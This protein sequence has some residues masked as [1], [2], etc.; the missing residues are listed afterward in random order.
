MVV[1]TRFL[2]SLSSH[3]EELPAFGYKNVGM[4]NLVLSTSAERKGSMPHNLSLYAAV[5]LHAKAMESPCSRRNEL[6]L[7]FKIITEIYRG[8]RGRR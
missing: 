8:E 5:P 2:T 6:N 7:S 1:P 4:H 3:C